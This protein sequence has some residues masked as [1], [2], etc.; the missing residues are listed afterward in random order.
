VVTGNE[1]EVSKLVTGKEYGVQKIVTFHFN[2]ISAV[3]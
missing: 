2:K 1:K 3:L